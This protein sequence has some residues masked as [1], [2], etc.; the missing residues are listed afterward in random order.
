MSHWCLGLSLL[1]LFSDMTWELT[2][3][4]VYLVT[5]Y[6]LLVFIHNACFGQIAEN[7]FGL[8]EKWLSPPSLFDCLLCVC[9]DFF[10][11][12][13]KL[14]KVSNNLC[15]WICFNFLSS[16]ANAVC[17]QCLKRSLVA[18]RALW[19]GWLHGVCDHPCDVISEVPAGLPSAC[20][21]FVI[22]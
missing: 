20:L 19:I 18:A 4:T 9:M 14:Y 1:F 15:E 12:L 17:F 2:D 7:K 21:L 13:N 8:G 11:F 22:K 3:C 6:Y 10:V 16:S 5:V